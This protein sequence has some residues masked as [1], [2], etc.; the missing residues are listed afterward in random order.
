M[1]FFDASAAA[2]RY[3]LEIGSDHVNE[4]WS[5]GNCSLRWPF[6]TASSPRP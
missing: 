1:I 4:L 6:F 2:K 5:G 3:F